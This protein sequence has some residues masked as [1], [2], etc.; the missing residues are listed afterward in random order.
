MC[1]CKKHHLCEKYYVCNSATCN[2]E[3]GK[4][5]ASIMN[6]SVIICEKVLMR[7]QT[8]KLS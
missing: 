2:C 4:H 3:N 1:Q 7:T 8:K 6:D 5:L